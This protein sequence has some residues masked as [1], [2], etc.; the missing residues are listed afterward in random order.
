MG[1]FSSYG[2]LVLASRSSFRKRGGMTAISKTSIQSIPRISDSSS[3][4]PNKGADADN[5]AT[6]LSQALNKRGETSPSGVSK[7]IPIADTAHIPDGFHERALDVRV[8]RQQLIA[9]NIANADTPNYK[10]VD[11]DLPQA[12]ASVISE[13]TGPLSLTT[14][15][16]M[17]LSEIAA[18]GQQSAFVKYQVPNQASADGNT[19]DMDVERTK[20]AENS[21]MYEFSLK[22]VGKK[23]ML[24]LLANLK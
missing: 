12:L 10:A 14:T 1:A 6:A 16:A 19:V 23:E 11:L 17:H 15:S 24:E 8:Y 20:F 2:D 3:S 7:H 21:F 4:H 9:A 5:F 13:T 18:P 22:R